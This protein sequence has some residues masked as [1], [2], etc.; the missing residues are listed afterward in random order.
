MLKGVTEKIR[1]IKIGDELTI[2][3]NP[4]RKINTIRSIVSRLNT[5]EP[6]SGKFFT[7]T[8]DLKIGQITIKAI[9]R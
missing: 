6:E 2:K 9:E 1:N 7:C 5:T 8:T 4:L 3:A